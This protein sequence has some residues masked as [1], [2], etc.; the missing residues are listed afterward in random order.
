MSIEYIFNTVTIQPD[1]IQE[2]YPTFMSELGKYLP[3][4]KP[5]KTRKQRKKKRTVGS[6]IDEIKDSIEI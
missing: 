3:V 5:L 1:Q 4:Q 6:L 2:Q